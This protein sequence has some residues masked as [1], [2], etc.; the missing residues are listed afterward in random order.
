MA[1]YEYRC[2]RCGLF[3]I[4][5]AMGTAPRAMA[6]PT[7]GAEAARVFSAPLLT[8]TPAALGK[9]L[10]REERSGYEPEVV[11]RVPPK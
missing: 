7:C 10:A 6:C 8:R 1:T 4:D 9:A 3:D 2:E 11:T 5:R